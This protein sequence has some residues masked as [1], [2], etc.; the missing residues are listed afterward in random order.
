M[1]KQ[2]FLNIVKNRK[3][4]VPILAVLFIPVLYAGM[5]L[6]AFW[7]PYEQLNELPVAIVNEDAGAELD[8]ERITVGK[9]LTKNLVESQEFH[10]VEVS[11]KQGEE[12]LKNQDYYM[13]IEIPSNFSQHAT[14]LLDEKPEKLMIEYKPNEGFNFLSAQIGESA[15]E[16]IRAEVNKQ[17][18]ASYSENLFA[19]ISKMGNGYGEAADGAE[20]LSAGADSL[21]S[22]ATDLKGYLEQL[23]SGSVQ[24]ADGSTALASGA[25]KAS[26]GA[27]E[28]N[29][30]LG[31]LTAGAGQLQQGAGKAADGAGQLQDGVASYTQGV[32]KVSNGLA[33]ANEKEQQL[34]EA[35]SQLQ[36]GATMTNQ[37]VGKLAGGSTQVT[38]GLETLSEQMAPILAS[39]P[40]EQQIAL[41]G[42]LEQLQQ[43]S[44]Q[45]SQGLGELQVGTEQL[46]GGMSQASSGAEKLATGHQELA[47]GLSTL[48]QSSEA[49][50]TGAASLAS[51]SDTLST[52]L[53]DLKNGLASASTGSNELSNGL[54]QLVQGSNELTSGTSQIASKSGELAAGSTEL[55]DGTAKLAEGTSSLQEKLADAS[56]EASA[57]NANEDTID[58][59]SSPV[60]VTKSAVNHVPNYGTG[61]APYFLSL[62]LFVGALLISIV[63]PLVQTAIPPTSGFAWAT[64][65]MTVLGIVGVVQALIA[66]A[67][68]IFGLGL[69]PE[70]LGW[71]IAIAIM[72]SFTYLAIVQLLVS[73]L[74][75]SG[76]FVA[77]IILILQLVTSA[78]TFPLEMIPQPLQIF[79]QWLPMTYSVQGFKA[80]I[81]STDIDFIQWNI[82][83]LLAFFI[84][85]AACTMTYFVILFKRRYS[86]VQ[87]A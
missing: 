34:N 20:K 32:A 43:G 58:M 78:G 87:E 52:K 28:L 27:T 61:F 38:A 83:I 14:T 62:G 26:N 74:G 35:L 2:E 45:V 67:I 55:V 65:K 63:F 7:D 66:V 21:T 82:G 25:V 4:L 68:L 54:Q 76:R 73:V 5:F 40:K 60:G 48:T 18:V 69:D 70:N 56:T 75:D 53:G 19:S 49:L 79:N 17:V 30:G 42:A 39:L 77:I 6:W 22:G 80:A 8:G 44:S 57:V 29:E 81:S 41:K 51:G 50:N 85:A 31:K 10:F 47:N 23:A 24:L 59:A 9:D 1:I 11:K 86:K 33:A 16:Q 72:T 13:V 64:S 37:S 15:I 12:A 46:S 3:L 36:Q 71:F 84:A